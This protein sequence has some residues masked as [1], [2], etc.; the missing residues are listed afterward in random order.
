MLQDKAKGPK[1]EKTMRICNRKKKGQIGLGEVFASNWNYNL[2]P[3][4]MH[5]GLSFKHAL[6]GIL[7]GLWLDFR[8][9]GKGFGRVLGGIFKHSRESGLLWVFLG[10]RDVFNRFFV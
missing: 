5:L 10:Y 2:F 3:L 7:A 4:L 6:G 1:H 8:G 9:L